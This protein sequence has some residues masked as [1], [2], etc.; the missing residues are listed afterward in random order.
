MWFLLQSLI[1]FAVMSSNIYWQWTPNGYLAG[2]IGAGAAFFATMGANQLLLW[3]RKQSR[4]QSTK[5]RAG[6][7]R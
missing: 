3:A 4:Q 1:I 5:Q 6:N 7:R 2:L